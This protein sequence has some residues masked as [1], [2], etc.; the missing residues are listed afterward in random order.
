MVS[1]KRRESYDKPEQCVAGYSEV[2]LTDGKKGQ[3]SET[4]V[5]LSARNEKGYFRLFI[6][7][8]NSDNLGD[9]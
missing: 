6:C 8:S 4:G 3:V 9:Y 7:G 5:Y 2:F 1:L